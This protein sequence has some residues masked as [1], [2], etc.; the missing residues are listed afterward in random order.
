MVGAMS[1]AIHGLTRVVCP[2][3]PSRSEKRGLER[4][5]ER[6]VVEE[7]KEADLRS[8]AG[9]LPRSLIAEREAESGT[10]WWTHWERRSYGLTR[11]V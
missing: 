5:E 10:T 8:R 11:V 4:Y 9:R 7:R 1:G 3:P 6:R 2:D